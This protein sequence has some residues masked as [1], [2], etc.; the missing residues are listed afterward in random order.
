[1]AQT[2]LLFEIGKEKERGV[3]EICKKLEIRSINIQPKDYGQK[4]GFLAGVQGFSKE[5]SIYQGSAFPMEML[6]FSGMDSDCV[7]VFLDAYKSSGLKPIPLKAVLTPHNIFWTPKE[8]FAEIFKEHI[9]LH[10]IGK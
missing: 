4:L 7:D 5:K 6:V 8:L 3:A 10:P 1:M 9:T 2:I